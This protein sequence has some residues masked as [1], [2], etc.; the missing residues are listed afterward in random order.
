MPLDARGRRHFVAAFP[1]LRYEVRPPTL[2]D[3]FLA[4]ATE[5]KTMSAFISWQQERRPPGTARIRLTANQPCRRPAARSR[6]A[7]DEP[8]LPH[9]R[10]AKSRRARPPCAR[11]PPQLAF[12]RHA[13][14]RVRTAHHVARVRRRLGRQIGIDVGGAPID[15][16]HYLALV[17]SPTRRSCH[18][19]SILFGAYIRMHFQKSWE[20]QLTTMVRLE[21]VVWGEDSGGHARDGLRGDRRR[22]AD[23]I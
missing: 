13:A 11:P 21:H 7:N 9:F 1:E 6:K 10:P 14:A 20:G 15:Y 19:S 3:L 22:G 2:D 8:Y 4:L 23:R 12:V 17:F 5:E 18:R 16:M